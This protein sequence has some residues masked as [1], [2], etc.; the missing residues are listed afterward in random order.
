MICH[1][2][3]HVFSVLPRSAHYVKV[4][5]LPDGSTIFEVCKPQ[6]KCISSCCPSIFTIHFPIISIFFYTVL[7][8]IL[9]ALGTSIKH[10][11][12][13]DLLMYLWIRF[14]WMLVQWYFVAPCVFSKRVSQH[15]KTPS[16]LGSLVLWPT[17]FIYAW[18][19][20]V[21]CSCSRRVDL[22]SAWQH[23]GSK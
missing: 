2:I 3:G 12:W 8:Y 13:F 1:V 10:F 19:I 17:W 9:E 5:T 14:L 16:N 20:A 15:T 4:C 11:V 22:V 6:E 21:A 7:D 23:G 18:R